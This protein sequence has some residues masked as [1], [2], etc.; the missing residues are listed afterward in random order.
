[1][2]RSAGIT[3]GGLPQPILGARL[4]V[5]SNIRQSPAI[6]EVRKASLRGYVP[7]ISPL[8]PGLVARNHHFM[9]IREATI[10]DAERRMADGGRRRRLDQA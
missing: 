3:T 10:D 4:R 5:Q 2:V 6:L 7:F 1:M 9:R 8:R